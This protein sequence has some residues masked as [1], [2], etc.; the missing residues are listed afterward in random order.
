MGIY[1][2]QERWVL[3]RRVIP[4]VLTNVGYFSRVW[5][6][7]IHSGAQPWC[8]VVF[9]LGQRH[10]FSCCGLRW[11][12]QKNGGEKEQKG[13]KKEGKKKEKEEEKREKIVLIYN[14]ANLQFVL[15]VLPILN[16]VNKLYVP[17][18]YVAVYTV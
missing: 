16:M 5:V 9:L 15:H 7:G 14:I 2:T 17:P 1:P 18:K 13:R 4:V 12:R 8:Q 10:F 3:G 6:L 11:A